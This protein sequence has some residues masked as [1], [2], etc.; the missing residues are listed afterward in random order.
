MS[1]GGC[2]LRWILRIGLL[3]VGLSILPLSLADNA[4]R[5][6]IEIDPNQA[7]SHAE[8]LIDAGRLPEAIAYIQSALDQAMHLDPIGRARLHIRL[9][10]AYGRLGVFDRVLDHIQMAEDL[11]ADLPGPE[12]FSMYVDALSARTMYFS[13]TRQLEKFRE[14]SLAELAARR[15]LPVEESKLDVA[16]INLGNANVLLGDLESAE[17]HLQEALSFAEKH[18]TNPRRMSTIHI[19]LGVVYNKRK[20][21]AIALRYWRKAIDAKRQQAP[22]SLS[23][24]N[25]LANSASAMLALGLIEEAESTLSEALAIQRDQLPGSTDLGR[26]LYAMGQIAEARGNPH[27]AEGLYRES[28]EIMDAKVPDLLMRR[29]PDAPFPRC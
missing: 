27:Q 21:H 14:A 7:T 12:A 3:T 18:R 13:R 2:A 25:V 15:R 1:P 19:N 6:E 29:T 28:L 17:R 4:E 23:L 16:L 8:Q 26:T 11:V 24:A 20:E 10:Y 22:D 9:A 5:G